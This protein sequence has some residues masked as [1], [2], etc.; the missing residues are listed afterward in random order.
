MYATNNFNLK[1]LFMKKMILYLL[2]ATAILV[3]SCSKST[4]LPPYTAPVVVNFTVTS[5]NHT[6]DTVSVGDTIYLNVAGTMYDTLNVYAYLTVTSS[7]SG[8]PVFNYGS[9]SSPIKLTRALGSSNASAMN[10]WTSS[11]RLIGAT[12]THKSKLT[13]IANFIYQLSLSSEGNGTATA[14]DAG[15]LNK[16]IYVQ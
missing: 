5:L 16:T 4:T 1:I 15:V 3:L 12:V 2:I 8:A 6:L 11:I 7:A 10:P 14:T 13:I 9:A